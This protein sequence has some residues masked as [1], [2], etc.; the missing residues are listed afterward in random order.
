VVWLLPA[1]RLPKDSAVSRSTQISYALQYAVLRTLIVLLR[2]LG[3]DRASSVN[4]A[5]W[6][7]FAPYTKRHKAALRH[8]NIAFPDKTDEQR[9]AIARQVWNNLGRTAAEALMIDA[10][11]REPERVRL[12]N[13]D[14]L[15]R[16][17]NEYGGKAVIAPMHSGN[18]E[19]FA[20][21]C[22]RY[23]L[24][25]ALI[26][27]RVK[28]PYADQF[29]RD[30]RE[31]YCPG[32]MYPKSESGVRRLVSWLRAGNIAVVLADQRARGALP[33]FFGHTAPSTPLPA[34]MARSFD[35]PL[36]AARAIR[37]NGAYF[38]L[39]I[40]EVPVPRDGDRDADI[41]AGTQAL[42]SV[43]ETWIREHPGQWMWAH[44]RWSLAG[45]PKDRSGR[46]K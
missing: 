16:I 40:K 31:K 27:Q 36:I 41:A 33:Q 11:A 9:E 3:I 42:Q 17:K 32:G 22:T 2:S 46:S 38:E 19:V 15:E 37:T 29:L 8:L 12:L 43:F 20:P 4:G 34:Y 18:W 1:K 45:P 10:I 28:N 13:P 7:T 23:Q 26:Y 25:A 39:E 30:M 24:G 14:L 5:L 35:A 6:E 44:R 21:A